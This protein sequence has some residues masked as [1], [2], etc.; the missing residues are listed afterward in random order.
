MAEK[1]QKA[2]GAALIWVLLALVAVGGGIQRM[3]HKNQQSPKNQQ[4]TA[5]KRVAQEPTTTLEKIL[6]AGCPSSQVEKLLGIILIRSDQ[7]TPLGT[8]IGIDKIEDANGPAAKA[9][10]QK[11]DIIL[12]P[13]EEKTGGCPRTFLGALLA[14]SWPSANVN[15]N[16]VRDGKVQVI[17][18]AALPEINAKEASK[19]KK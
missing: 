11:G 8:G 9:G 13:G 6:V 16:V 1:R 12:G 10:L 19:P 3:S 15:L 14:A 2:R 4:A 18:L 7:K 5:S 17:V